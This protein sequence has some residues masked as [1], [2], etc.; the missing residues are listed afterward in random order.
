MVKLN[1]SWDERL[2]EEFS[3]EYY[4]T[5]REFLKKEYSTKTV[6]PSAYDIFNSIK[7]VDYDDVSV[8]ILGQDPYHEPNQAQPPAGAIP[9][10][11]YWFGIACSYKNRSPPGR[12]RRGA[13]AAGNG[14]RGFGA[15]R[16]AADRS[17][18][19]TDR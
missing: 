18:T 11:S 17:P 4:L 14:S 10:R 6:Y 9:W 13:S 8:V 15:S 2:K 7:K 19:P 16:T 1:N 3:S 12:N 5:L